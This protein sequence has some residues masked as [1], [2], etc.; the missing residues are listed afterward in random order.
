MLDQPS[1]KRSLMRLPKLIEEMKIVGCNRGLDLGARWK[2]QIRI[3]TRDPD[4][5]VAEANGEKLLVAELLGDHDGS[6]EGDVFLVRGRPEPNMLGAHA[7][8]NGSSDP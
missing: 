6:L 5:A 8:A 3:D 1:G 7:D 4:L 2:G